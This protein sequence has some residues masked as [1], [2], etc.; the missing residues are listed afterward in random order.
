MK[1]V[2][3][4][5]AI[6]AVL[7][8][9]LGIYFVLTSEH[10]LVTH[11]KGIIAESE[12]KHLNTNLILMLIIV[13]PTMVLLFVVAWRYRSTNTKAQHDPDK[14]YGPFKELLLWILPA[15]VIAVM[16]VFTWKDTHELDPYRPL[17]SEVKPLTIQVVA[18]DWKWLFIYPEQK[19]A[20]VNFV[21]FP[22]KTP[23]RFELAADG[24]PMNSFWIP[25]LSGQIYAMTGMVTPLHIMANEPG[26][27]SGKAAEIN[28]Q[29]YAGMTFVAKAT[30]QSD[31]ES[32]IAEVKGFPLQLNDHT[33]NELYQPSE[34]HPVTVYSNV[35]GDLF[36]KIVMKYMHPIHDHGQHHHGN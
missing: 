24:S 7:C 27:Y 4:T 32:W 18:L 3:F 23:I 22:E 5:I 28:G 15:I 2:L 16:V 10:A 9:F 34:D 25:Q 21:Q 19:I 8:F 6:V 14:T 31:F 36:N 11:P 30:S 12:L 29:G 33:Y 13:V 1:R 17:Q 26:I 35:D 20:T